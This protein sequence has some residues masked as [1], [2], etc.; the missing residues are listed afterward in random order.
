MSEIERPDPQRPGFHRVLIVVYAV[1]TVAAGAR[2]IVQLAQ[3][4]GEA[5][6]AYTLSALSACTYALGWYAIHRAA[7]GRTGFA[8]VMLWLE[9]CGVLVV[10]T[11]SLVE[12]DWFPDASVWSDYGIGYGFVP[13]ILPVAGLVWLHREERERRGGSTTVAR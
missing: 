2:A 12:T 5:P 9:L 6:V 1:F 7:S 3:N 13:A 10:G 4:A 8:H 11:L